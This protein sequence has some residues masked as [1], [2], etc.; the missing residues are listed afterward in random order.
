MNVHDVDG[1]PTEIHMYE[2]W[3]LI[4]YEIKRYIYFF[5]T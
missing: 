2:L 3:D 4:H 1:K 5:I